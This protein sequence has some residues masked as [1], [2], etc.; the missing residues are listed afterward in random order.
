[1]TGPHLGGSVDALVDGQLSPDGRDGALSH[2]AVC[3]SCRAEV[4]SNRALK[5]RL[6]QL[7][8]PAPPGELFARLMAVPPGAPGSPARAAAAGRG[9]PGRAL[10]LGVALAALGAGAGL[11]ARGDGGGS[12][13]AGLVGRVVDPASF[14]LAQHDSTAREVVLED[15][16]MSVVAAVS[17]R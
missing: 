9:L 12:V 15:P 10:V 17:S 3:P 6:G 2:V 16:A 4:A 1:M 7:G 5:A 11:A 13:P 14:S 8:H